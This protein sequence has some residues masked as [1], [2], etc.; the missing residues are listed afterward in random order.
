[1]DAWPLPTAAA[2]LSQNERWFHSPAPLGHV[3][4][5]AAGVP[6]EY[7]MRV[8]EPEPGR[9]LTESD[10]GSSSVTTFTVSPQGGHH[11]VVAARLY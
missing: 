10:T 6:A 3:G 9:I 2:L 1:M 8:A 11:G 4:R 7:R 5:E